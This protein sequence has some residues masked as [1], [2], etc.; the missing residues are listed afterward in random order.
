MEGFLFRVFKWSPDFNCREAPPLADVWVSL[1]SLPIHLCE[2][3]F[4][5]IFAGSM[6]RFL[7]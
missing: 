4:L 3:Y 1:P 5:R 6:G 2:A 7:S